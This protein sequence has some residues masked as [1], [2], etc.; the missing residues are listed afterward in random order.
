MNTE[1][2]ITVH[3]LSTH[4]Q[5]EVAFFNN[6]DEIGLIEILN[7]DETHYIHNDAIYKIEKIIR[8]H[9]DLD[10]NIEGVAIILNLLQKIDSLEQE[11]TTVKNSLRIYD[12]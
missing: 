7:I 4:Y 3:T 5:V 10:V 1:N 6:L 9:Q 2:L 11:L 12:N 8:I